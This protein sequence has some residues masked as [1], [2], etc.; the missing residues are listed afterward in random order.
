MSTWRLSFAWNLH[1]VTIEYQI[2]R[3]QFHSANLH[4]LASFAYGAAHLHNE[5]KDIF[6][7][8]GGG[9]ILDFFNFW[10]MNQLR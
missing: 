6:F 9:E 1:A 2:V 5:S 10:N 3:F 7:R 8:G 4:L